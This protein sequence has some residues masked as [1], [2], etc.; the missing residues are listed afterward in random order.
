MGMKIIL[1]IGRKNCGKTKTL[2]EV[3]N[4]LT[5]GMKTLP[6]KKRI[7]KN[8]KKDFYCDFTYKKKKI[9]IY[10]AGDSLPLLLKAVFLYSNVD[11]LIMPFSNGGKIKTQ[12]L[13][14]FKKYCV[15]Q[16]YIDKTLYRKVKNKITNPS[17]N[18][19]DCKKI[20]SKI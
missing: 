16:K 15:K 1:L 7:A 5:N 9:A 8:S 4:T 10:T 18:I 6:P 17:A 19:T 20:I 14:Y 2:T 3:Y 12:L 13:S 11:Y